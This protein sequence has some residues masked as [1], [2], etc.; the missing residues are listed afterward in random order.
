MAI[1]KKRIER[2]IAQAEQNTKNAIER[3]RELAD[4]LEGGS[5]RMAGMT[6]HS[7]GLNFGMSFDGVHATA[8]PK[9]K[10]GRDG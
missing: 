7:D 6:M 5:I 8:I 9:V 4:R 2:D 1:T 3:L 10:V